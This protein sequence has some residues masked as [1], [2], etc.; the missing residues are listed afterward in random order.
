MDTPPKSFAIGFL[1][2]TYNRGCG[3][4]VANIAAA[5]LYATRKEADIVAS[6]LQGGT[7]IYELPVKPHKRTMKVGPRW[8]P[9]K[10]P[11]PTAGQLATLGV[12]LNRLRDE[13]TANHKLEGD[14]QDPNTR[15]VFAVA[16]FGKQ[17]HA[18]VVLNVL[19]YFGVDGLPDPLDLP[20]HK[21][22]KEEQ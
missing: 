8:I 7:T 22:L 20:H 21:A 15:E 12:V 10:H 3:F 6:Q 18:N 5:T 17:A 9:V 4:E 14:A 16:R 1:N 11:R 19:K 13:A 2:G